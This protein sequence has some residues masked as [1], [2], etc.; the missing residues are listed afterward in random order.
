M[1]INSL[2]RI[3]H[4]EANL[5]LIVCSFITHIRVERGMMDLRNS[6]LFRNQEREREKFAYDACSDFITS[7][8][9]RNSRKNRRVIIIIIHKSQRKMVIQ[10]EK[11]KE[12]V[13]ELL[14]SLPFKKNKNESLRHRH[15]LIFFFTEKYP[16]RFVT[17]IIHHHIENYINN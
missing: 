16:H 10:R 6:R 14:S 12:V 17:V 1:K 4:R 2:G 3:R 5:K 8:E 9:Y 11:P 15:D 7:S 13:H